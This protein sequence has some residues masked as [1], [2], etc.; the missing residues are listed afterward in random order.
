MTW[1]GTP[2]RDMP[3]GLAQTVAPSQEPV[4]LETAKT[5]LRIDST[6]DD[7][8]LDGYLQAARAHIETV[9]R[10]QLVTATYRLDLPAFPSVLRLPRPPLQ[11]VTSI[12]YTDSAGDPQTVLNTTYTVATS[13]IPAYVAPV[14]AWPTVTEGPAAVQ[15]T[16][17][18]GF[19]TPQQVPSVY[20]ALILLLVADMYEHRE[21]VLELTRLSENKTYMRLL[22]AAR[23]I[24][25]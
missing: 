23:L 15:V 14:D 24:E 8:L 16:F 19:G 20:K 5:H 3:W 22:Q 7:L 18:A 10:Y 21:A 4:D 12:G 25:V 13:V 9:T 2:L 6:V 17:V 1:T 11:S